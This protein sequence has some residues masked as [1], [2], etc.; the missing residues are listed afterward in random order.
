V[1][2]VDEWARAHAREILL[3]VSFGVGAALLV[4]GALAL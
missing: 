1:R 2:S 4:R 3:C